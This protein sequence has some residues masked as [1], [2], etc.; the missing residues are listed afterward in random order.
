V[1]GV[2]PAATQEATM[3][4]PTQLI[5]YDAQDVARMPAYGLPVVREV[6]P[7]LEPVVHDTFGGLTGTPSPN[8]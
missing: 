2:N 5:S 4:N 6:P 7:A 3:R 8:H 1:V